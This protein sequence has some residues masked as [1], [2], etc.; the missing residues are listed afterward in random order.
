MIDDSP[1]R[2]SK[3]KSQKSPENSA[4]FPSVDQ[5]PEKTSKKS[6]KSVLFA[7]NVSL[8]DRYTNARK[9]IFPAPTS[10]L[11]SE[12]E[13]FDQSE[14]ENFQLPKISC[15]LGDINIYIYPMIFSNGI[16]GKSL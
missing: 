3:P 6:R 16:A 8:G 15:S 7:D 4:H 5:A 9:S 1:L 11:D 10:G 2:Q 14:Y 13:V 12:D